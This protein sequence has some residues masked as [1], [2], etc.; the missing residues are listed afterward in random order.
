MAHRSARTATLPRPGPD[1]RTLRRAASGRSIFP[2]LFEDHRPARNRNLL[3]LFEHCQ[4][5]YSQPEDNLYV[6]LKMV[7]D[8]RVL[9]DLSALFCRWQRRWHWGFQRYDRKTGL[10]F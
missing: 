5:P 9:S 2:P 10:S 8:R 7:A 1:G 4:Y 3:T 6:K